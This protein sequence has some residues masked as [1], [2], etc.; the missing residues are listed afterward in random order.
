MPVRSFALP[1]LLAIAGL[2]SALAATST[3]EAKPA[4]D[5]VAARAMAQ[6][7]GYADVAWLLADAEGRSILEAGGESLDRP[8]VPAS[9]IKP[10]LAL[11]AL[12]TG[13]LARADEVVPWNG[14][15]YPTQR[16]WE[17]DMALDEAMRSS[18][19][20]Y[21]REL[22]RRIGRERLAEWLRRVGYGNARIGEDPA[23]AWIDGVLRITPRQQMAFIGRLQ[24]G[25]LPFAQRH[26]AAVIAAMRERSDGDSAVFGKTGTQL[27]NAEG[28]GVGWWVGWVQAGDEV[29]PFA[30]AVPLR[31]FDG[32]DK[33]LALA[34]AMLEASG[35]RAP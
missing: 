32:R 18:S 22:A 11:I 31:G 35:V 27:A 10:L 26:R 4:F 24:R 8:R 20:P 33:R 23:R 6:S 5:A 3:T 12:E 7:A 2:S 25:E 29:H 13:A 15:R 17:H 9:S 19:E 14:E 30:L 16:H 28:D 34:D 21:F 1:T